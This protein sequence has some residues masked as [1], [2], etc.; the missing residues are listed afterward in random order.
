MKNSHKGHH[1]GNST[2][3]LLNKEIILSELNILPGETILDVGCGDGYMAK[4]FSKINKSGKIYALD[5]SK[6][7]IKHLKKET[8][9]TNISPILADITTGT[10]LEESSIDLI[11]LSTV[12]HIFSSQKID[13]FGKE[14]ERILKPNGRL[15][16]VEIEKRETPIGP[17][18]NMRVS[19]GEMEKLIKMKPASLVKVGEYFYM[20]IFQN[21]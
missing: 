4:E 3:I 7:A 16:M 1:K 17:P 8:E 19:P 15:A 10:E 5:Q 2:E 9:G 20:Q 11:Y 6:E 18:M 14:V 13:D 21:E 12:F